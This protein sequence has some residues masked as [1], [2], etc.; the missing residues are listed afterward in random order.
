[1]AAT[2]KSD[3]TDGL[4]HMQQIQIQRTQPSQTIRESENAAAGLFVVSIVSTAPNSND[5]TET[6]LRFLA[7]VEGCTDVY[8][9]K[10]SMR[11]IFLTDLKI[12]LSNGSSSEST[13][14]TNS[15]S[16]GEGNPLLQSLGARA[17]PPKIRS[18]V[19][20]LD[21]TVA[22]KDNDNNKNSHRQ[23]TFEETTTPHRQLQVAIK[24]RMPSGIVRLLWSTQIPLCSSSNSTGDP[25][26][27]KT[28]TIA[29]SL[30]DLSLRLFRHQDN[31][32]T[33]L[34]TLQQQFALLERDR[35]G[36][37]DTATALEGEW[38][39]EK[40]KLF[41]NFCDLYCD[42]QAHAETLQV[43]ALQQEI[44]SLKEQQLTAVKNENAVP[45]SARQP[46]PPLPECL[47]N[48]P[49]D[50]DREDY[51]PELVRLL[52][53][54]KPLPKKPS[55]KRRIPQVADI[56]NGVGGE[57]SSSR[58]KTDPCI[59][60]E[61]LGTGGFDANFKHGRPNKAIAAKRVVQETTDPKPIATAEARPVPRKKENTK[62]RS[63]SDTGSDDDFVD[64]AMQAEI[65]ANLQ[66]LQPLP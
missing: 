11:E 16:I 66:S 49:D 32:A 17:L 18:F 14:K 39:K 8:V 15:S 26:L 58:T 31:L 1:M 37:K 56:D 63:D 52:A 44:A 46:L 7:A 19:A 12:D 40:S 54:G 60:E 25:N 55:R 48:A 62:T 30:F 23:I 45:P 3:S 5:D 64:R 65:M 29:D 42:K 13:I 6:E 2:N 9:R 47:Q 27:N 35:N 43:Q 59:E 22:Q 10:Q 51:D 28:H 61:R 21:S 20:L 33:Q 50:M 38:E 24:E 36:W 53:A 57:H 41:Q 34:E 4:L